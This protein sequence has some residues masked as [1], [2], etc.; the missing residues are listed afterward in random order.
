MARMTELKWSFANLT[1]W[2]GRDLRGSCT[3]ALGS[4]SAGEWCA[5]GPLRGA[6]RPKSFSDKATCSYDKR[7]P[8]YDVMTEP[9]NTRGAW[10]RAKLADGRRPCWDGLKKEPNKPQRP[11]VDGRAKTWGGESGA[12][13]KMDARR[14]S[15][16]PGGGGGQQKYM[17][18]YIQKN[19]VTSL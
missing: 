13:Q 4:G 19:T 1:E 6:R 15:R 18:Q 3:R 5:P 17:L 14:N 7:G 8:P 12:E 9:K 10:R 16:R 2:H 11:Q